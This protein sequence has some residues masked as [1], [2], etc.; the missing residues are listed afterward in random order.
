MATQEDEM[1]EIV[2][3]LG[4]AFSTQVNIPPELWLEMG[5]RDRNNP[6]LIGSDGRNH[7]YDELLSLAGPDIAAAL[8]PDEI[9]E[10]HRRCQAGVAAIGARLLQADDV[11]LWIAIADDE[12]FL[13]G[14][15]N[16][17]A[18]LVYWG[19]SVPYRPRPVPA[20][21]NPI[22]KGSAWAYGDED[23]EF[24]GAPALGE[25]LIRDLAASGFDVSHARQLRDGQSI[26]HPYG[27]A[28]TRLLG[29]LRPPTPWLPVV[30]NASYPPNTP[31]PARS[32]DFGR[33][34]AE[35]V[36]SWTE[37]A[38]VGV[39]TIGNFSHPVL[40]EP[41]DRRLFAAIE[42]GDAEALRA[43]PRANFEGGNGQAK[44]WIIAAGALEALEMHPIDYVAC[45]RSPASTGCGMPFAYWD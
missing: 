34:L 12:R 38:R 16:F 40:D 31:T 15:D 6:V 45:Y 41:L 39:L 14:D 43:L 22:A 9:V 29:G 19:E 13:F 17:P 27:F 3:G 5:E 7:S 25:H 26:G 32:Y 4:S 21:A 28:L 36:R 44:T 35:A 30:I 42:A 11:D 33:A 10:R 24:A 1:A 23:V 37:P 20:D 8:T 2:L 18:W